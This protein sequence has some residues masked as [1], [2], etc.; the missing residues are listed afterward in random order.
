M[1]QGELAIVTAKTVAPISAFSA[2]NY[3]ANL[4]VFIGVTIV[5]EP[6]LANIA[7]RIRLP[8]LRRISLDDPDAGNHILDFL[9]GMNPH[10]ALCLDAETAGRR[11]RAA[12][13]SR[14]SRSRSPAL[15][16][17]PRSS[18]AICAAPPRR[19]R[20]A[21]TRLRHLALHDPLCGLPN[22]NFF[23]ERLRSRDQ[24][25]PRGGAVRPPCS[26]SISIT[27]RTSTTRSAIRSATN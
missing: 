16:C 27:S 8:N 20:R 15:R 18:S 1:V 3:Q 25:G 4:P 14:S 24:G 11:D 6:L 26:I 13:S 17:S 9:D 22:R 2:R 10:R 12:A 19:S 23:G 21:R 7:S 5:D